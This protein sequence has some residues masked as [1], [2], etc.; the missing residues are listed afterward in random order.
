MARVDSVASGDAVA[1]ADDDG[2]GFLSVDAGCG[3]KEQQEQEA[4]HTTKG[5]GE[6]VKGKENE[7]RALRA[8]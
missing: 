7:S 5:K 6:S 2:G 1:K 8:N 4:L 3:E